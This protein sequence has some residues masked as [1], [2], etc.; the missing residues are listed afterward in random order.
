MKGVAKKRGI[1]IV[2]LGESTG[3]R[4]PDV[5]GAS[6]IGSKDDPVEYQ[7]LRESP[8]AAGVLGCVL[9]GRLSR[10][11]G[12]ARVAA[13]ALAGSGA[14]CLV[15]PLAQDAPTGVL[16]AALLF[17]GFMVIADSPQYSALSARACPPELIGSALA[18]QN[19]IGFFIT[20]VAISVATASWTPLGASVAWLLL[21]G[22]VLGLLGLAPLLRQPR[23]APAGR[24]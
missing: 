23:A 7:R 4:M 8:W 10:S 18:I 16:L 2:F 9:G 20:V 15:F 22:P 24:R 1:P 19:S 17:W 14:M 13:G 3:A 5:M 21:P 6:S 11:L 12:G